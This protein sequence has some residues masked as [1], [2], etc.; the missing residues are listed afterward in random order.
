[1]GAARESLVLWR[2]AFVDSLPVLMG[3]ST[4]GFAAG[5]FLAAA[6]HVPFAPAWG[7]VTSVAFVSGTLSFAI[8]KP[9]AEHASLWS[10]A[11]LTLALNFRY[12]FYGLSMLSRWKGIG[13][14]RKIFLIHLL[15][16]ENY[17][18]EVASPIRRPRAYERYC[19]RLSFLNLSYWF[20]GIVSGATAVWGL[21]RALSPERIRAATNGIEFAMVALFLVIFT[22]QARGWFANGK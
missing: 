7:A 10:V 20:I 4:M 16:D 9:M 19:L 18:L 22:D 1:M 12:A 13:L 8:V 2:L 11:L 14:W 6:G 21:E 17:A 5:A 15:T 3:Y